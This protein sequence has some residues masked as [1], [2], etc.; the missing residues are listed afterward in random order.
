M[1][2]F[3]VKSQCV[4]HRINHMQGMG[5]MRTCGSKLRTAYLVVA[6]ARV[7]RGALAILRALGFTL[8]LSHFF[9]PSTSLSSSPPL[10]FPPLSR[11]FPS[12][13]LEVGPLNTA[14]GL[15][16]SAVSGV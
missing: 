13:T 16:G 15:I 12:L 10:P 1:S 11:P 7:P 14:R 9:P 5:K 4:R 2:D 3:Q 6:T 8:F